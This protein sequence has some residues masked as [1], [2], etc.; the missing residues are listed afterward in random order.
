M[1]CIAKWKKREQARNRTRK[2]DAK[3]E[4]HEARKK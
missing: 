2:D 4:S 1:K 3:V